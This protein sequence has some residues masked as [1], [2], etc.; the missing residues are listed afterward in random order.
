MRTGRELV[1]GQLNSVYLR[2]VEILDPH[3]SQVASLGTVKEIRIAEVWLMP[4]DG[5]F[6]SESFLSK[7]SFNSI[8]ELLDF[9]KGDMGK[10]LVGF[11]ATLRFSLLANYFELLSPLDTKWY[12]WVRDT[13]NGQVI[14]VI[15][16]HQILMNRAQTEGF[17]P[18]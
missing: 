8:K 16:G 4:S 6:I 18:Q 14:S 2:A 12:M 17:I 15:F 3:L 11:A 1:I 9:C 7:A 13:E 5:T 10:E